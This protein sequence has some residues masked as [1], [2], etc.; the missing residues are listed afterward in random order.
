MRRHVDMLQAQSGTVLSSAHLCI[1]GS[2]IIWHHLAPLVTKTDR[3]SRFF[4]TPTYGSTVEQ[5]A[6]TW[7][8]TARLDVP[9]TPLVQLMNA[10]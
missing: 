7:H 1:S 10:V 9:K 6:A 4:D 3:L 2:V 8:G 5:F